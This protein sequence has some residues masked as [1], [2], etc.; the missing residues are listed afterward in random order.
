MTYPRDQHA[1]YFASKREAE[2]AAKRYRD[3]DGDPD[4]AEVQRVEIKSRGD[5]LH[6]LNALGSAY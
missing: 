6:I 3:D 1:E 5:L 4:A 2:A